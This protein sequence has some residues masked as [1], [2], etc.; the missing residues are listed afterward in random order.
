MEQTFHVFRYSSLISPYMP[1]VA[2]INALSLILWSL[3]SSPAFFETVSYICLASFVIDIAVRFYEEDYSY[4]KPT[5]HQFNLLIVIFSLLPGYQSLSFLTLFVYRDT[6]NTFFKG[7]GLSYYA[8]LFLGSVLSFSCIGYHL[9]STA[10]P[11]LFGTFIDS[12]L[13]AMQI[14]TFDHWVSGILSPLFKAGIYEGIFLSL[15]FWAFS[16]YYLIKIGRFI[17]KG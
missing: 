7:K 3:G 14:L 13:K 5:N 2:V 9:F 8:C 17:F 12:F 10:V 4:L 15:G 11:N 16:F 6:L 1:Y